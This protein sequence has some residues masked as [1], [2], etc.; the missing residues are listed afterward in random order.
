MV[1]ATLYAILALIQSI[2]VSKYANLMVITHCILTF[3]TLV[4]ILFCHY[5]NF[6]HLSSVVQLC[7]GFIK[8]EQEFTK[9]FGN[10]EIEEGQKSTANLSLRDMIFL[11]TSVG[12]GGATVFTLDILRN[13]CF[14][15]YVG[16]WMS[17]QCELAKTG[18]LPSEHLEFGRI[19][20]KGDYSI[21]LDVCLDAFACWMRLSNFIGI[22]YGR[23]LFSSCAC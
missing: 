12:I 19:R 7:N 8:V 21:T 9:H 18:I 1:I 13:P 4:L 20:D 16:Y 17:S 10:T 14:P 11:L 23:K 3:S 15:V 5:P 22:C 2:R 6:G